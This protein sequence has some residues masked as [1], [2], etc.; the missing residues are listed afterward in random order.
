MQSLDNHDS[1][2]AEIKA[3]ENQTGRGG[4][5]DV[6]VHSK[7]DGQWLRVAQDGT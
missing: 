1:I 5:K 2:A 3:V 6:L 7:T 4:S